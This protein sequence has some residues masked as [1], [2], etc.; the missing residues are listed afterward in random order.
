MDTHLRILGKKFGE[1]TDPTPWRNRFSLVLAQVPSIRRDQGEVKKSAS[2]FCDLSLTSLS[3]DVS[4]GHTG[5]AYFLARLQRFKY[6]DREPGEPFPGRGLR[7]YG[8]V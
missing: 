6:T 4:I 1:T 8:Q 7:P 5:L 2:E 3:T